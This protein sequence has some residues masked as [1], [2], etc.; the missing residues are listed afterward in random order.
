MIFNLEI[1]E[2][3]SETTTL[4]K[5]IDFFFVEEFPVCPAPESRLPLIVDLMDGLPPSPAASDGGAAPLPPRMPPLRNML[6]GH[7]PCARR[8]KILQTSIGL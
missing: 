4:L 2:F 6:N 3:P 5:T 8:K 1:I 7:S